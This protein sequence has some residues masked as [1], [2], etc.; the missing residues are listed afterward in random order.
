MKCTVVIATYN[1]GEYVREQLESILKQTRKP[2]RILI[3]DDGSD[4]GTPETC[5]EALQDSGIG[6]SIEENEVRRGAAGNFMYL[7]GR[8]ETDVVFFCDQDDIWEPGKIEKIM[9][10]FEAH[11]DCS[12][13]FTDAEVWYPGQPAGQTMNEFLGINTGIP[14]GAEG[15]MDRD[16]LWDQLIVRNLANGMSMAIRADVAAK[17]KDGL[18]MLHDSWY[19]L[20]AAAMGRVY[21][22]NSPTAKYR[23][24]AANV[25][26][27]DR[28]LTRKRTQD[29]RRKVINSFEGSR[30]RIRIIDEL[31][32]EHSMLSAA[33]REKLQ[34]NKEYE[35]KREN[36]ILHHRPVSYL[37]NQERYRKFG[38]CLSKR[39][40][41]RDLLVLGQVFSRRT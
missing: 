35:Q 40:T 9:D 15:F 24:H 33:N 37:I 41:I 2:D 3:A 21:C 34:A 28:K 17:Q 32:A 11:P 20:Q 14:K 27:A 5:R 29:N 18:Q 6:F 38:F 10:I 30:E 23:Q 26:G 39:L 19:M 13:V 1:G 36:A 22:I 4:D 16:L 25:S 8:A 7:A 31:Q 12:M